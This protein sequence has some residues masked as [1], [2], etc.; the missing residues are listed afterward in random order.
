MSDP[1][2][3]AEWEARVAS[4]DDREPGHVFPPR[5]EVVKVTEAEPAQRAEGP[6][7]HEGHPGPA[8]KQPPRTTPAILPP[9]GERRPLW[10]RPA[11]QQDDK[12]EP[13]G[14]GG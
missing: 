3:P 6:A 1:I 13:T 8:Q 12:G 9:E 11:G 4:G 2:P 14:P 7:G 10:R 5:P